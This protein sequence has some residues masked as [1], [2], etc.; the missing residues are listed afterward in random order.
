MERVA[1]AKPMALKRLYL[2]VASSELVSYSQWR[3]ILILLC[4]SLAAEVES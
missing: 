1:S 4:P 3:K 2:E